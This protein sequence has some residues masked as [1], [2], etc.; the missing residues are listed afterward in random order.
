MTRRKPKSRKLPIEKIRE[1]TDAS[2]SGD[3]YWTQPRDR[4]FKKT[5]QKNDGKSRTPLKH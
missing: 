2:G 4:V 5:R 1:L 3:P